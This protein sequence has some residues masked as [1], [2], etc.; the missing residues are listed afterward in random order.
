MNDKNLDFSLFN[1]HDLLKRWEED[2]NKF[3]T[4]NKNQNKYIYHNTEAYLFT[5]WCATQINELNDDELF[6][7]MWLWAYYILNLKS[8]SSTTFLQ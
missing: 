6:Y 8:F 2:K 4:N 3:K 5:C 7:Q 1:E